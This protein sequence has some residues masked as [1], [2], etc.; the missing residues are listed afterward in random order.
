VLDDSF[1]F[2]IRLSRDPGRAFSLVWLVW[3]L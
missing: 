1:S 3:R 2:S